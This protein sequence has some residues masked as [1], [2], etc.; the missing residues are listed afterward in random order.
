MSRLGGIGTL[1]LGMIA[2]TAVWIPAQ[3]DDHFA[4]AERLCL[5]SAAEPVPA[6]ARADAEGWM[7]VPPLFAGSLPNGVLLKDARLKSDINRLYL[8]YVTTQASSDGQDNACTVIALPGDGDLMA[9]AER[10]AG[11]VSDDKKKGSARYS[12][13]ESEGRHL[14]GDEATAKFKTVPA[15]AP[16][17]RYMAVSADRERSIVLYVAPEKSSN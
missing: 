16:H 5:E 2:G 15:A 13:F 3:A 10:W 6:L 9:Q 8:L 11:V 17:Y 12:F 4:V 7:P 1:L 14:N